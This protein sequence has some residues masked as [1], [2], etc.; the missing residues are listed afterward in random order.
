MKGALDRI[1]RELDELTGVVERVGLASLAQELADIS[2]R[3]ELLREGE[4]VAWITPTT[5][6][7]CAGC[8]REVRHVALTIR[9]TLALGTETAGRNA[10][11]RAE[12]LERI[13]AR[14]GGRGGR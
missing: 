6:P 5:E 4:G 12:E 7:R 10:A 11:R 1:S 3:V 14:I 13:A 9:A 8:A 2:R